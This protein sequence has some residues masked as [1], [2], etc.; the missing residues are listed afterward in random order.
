MV[1]EPITC[2]SWVKVPLLSVCVLV[3]ASPDLMHPIKMKQTKCYLSIG[4]VKLVPEQHSTRTA[5]AR[6]LF[7]IG[8]HESFSRGQEEVGQDE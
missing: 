4:L 7:V 2:S 1:E 5:P 6:R 3:K 8:L